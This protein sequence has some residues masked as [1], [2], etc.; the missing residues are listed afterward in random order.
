MHQCEYVYI[1]HAATLPNVSC[2]MLAQMLGLAKCR[3]IWQSR[4]ELRRHYHDRSLAFHS[5]GNVV[6]DSEDHIGCI[7][8]RCQPR[9]LEVHG[10][11]YASE[12]IADACAAYAF[13]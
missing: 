2:Y 13:N 7:D 5:A 10:R 12:K 6:L 8:P 3:I 1:R 9:A 4:Q 11:R